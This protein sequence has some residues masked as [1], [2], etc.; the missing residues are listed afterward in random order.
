MERYCDAPT[1][2]LGIVAQIAGKPIPNQ[3]NRVG[4]AD[5]KLMNRD[6]AVV[7][8]LPPSS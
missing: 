1:A 6:F 7:E 2:H 3:E 8:I 5:F 4:R